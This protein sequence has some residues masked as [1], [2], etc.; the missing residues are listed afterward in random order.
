MTTIVHRK[1]SVAGKKPTDAQLVEGE[2]AVNTHDGK[3]YTLANGT[4][5][6]LA[7][8]WEENG[9]SISYSLG[10]VGIGEQNPQSALTVKTS[11]WLPVRIT[12][13]SNQVG[14]GLS[15]TA[16]GGW[17]LYDV[18]RDDYDLF[19][20]N[21]N[22]GIGT[23]DPSSGTSTYYDDL[24]I[25]NDTSGTGAGITI[26]ANTTNGFGGIDLPNGISCNVIRI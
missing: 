26:Q 19:M 13:S 4:V 1:S 12:R 23:S 8:Q 7:G 16:S 2:I 21:G 11:N 10:N 5:K 6:T 17:G 22:V 9:T 3:A 18:A 20:K 14:I 24:V 15:T 25:K